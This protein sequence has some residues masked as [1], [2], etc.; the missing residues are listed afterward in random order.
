MDRESPHEKID[1]PASA[2]IFFSCL[3]FRMFFLG[4]AF[5]PK[6]KSKISKDAPPSF[7]EIPND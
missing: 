7:C 5:F 6:K 4:T 1:E 3:K 2:I